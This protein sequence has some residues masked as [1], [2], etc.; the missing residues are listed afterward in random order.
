MDIAYVHAASELEKRVR[1]AVETHR[2][3]AF[4]NIDVARLLAETPMAFERILWFGRHLTLNARS[5]SGFQEGREIVH[6]A[7][8][9]GADPDERA[10][11]G[12][13]SYVT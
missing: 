2:L 10:T 9:P 6:A 3:E 7:S 1:R 5:A 13:L 11:A 8:R 12:D 4:D